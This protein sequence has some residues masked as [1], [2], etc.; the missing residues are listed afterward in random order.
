[1]KSLEERKKDTL[2]KLKYIGFNEMESQKL[3]RKNYS[4]INR[5][6]GLDIYFENSLCNSYNRVKIEKLNLE[7]INQIRQ[8]FK[9]LSLNESWG[10]PKTFYS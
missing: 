3:A 10:F 9:I 6:F 4:F 5:F 1:M 2:E 8:V 7:K